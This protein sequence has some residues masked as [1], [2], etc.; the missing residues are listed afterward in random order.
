[1][2]PHGDPNDSDNGSGSTL[3]ILTNPPHFYADRVLQTSPA[4]APFMTSNIV[5]LRLL[6]NPDPNVRLEIT[7]V[8]VAMQRQPEKLR[9]L[10]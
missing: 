1:M 10:Q 2:A 4:L 9:K 6:R 3:S 7:N 5:S 8:P